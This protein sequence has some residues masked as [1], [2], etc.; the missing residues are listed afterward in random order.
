MSTQ[1]K[2]R[3]CVGTSKRKTDGWQLPLI[4]AVFLSIVVGAF[5][6][7]A[8]AA[9]SSDPLME[10]LIQKGMLTREEADKVKAE[11]EAM[12]TNAPGMEAM[13]AAGSKWK[14]SDAIKNLELFGDARVRYEHRE[15]STPVSDRIDLDRARLALRVGLRGEAF[16]NFYYGLRLDTSSNPRSPW[17]TLGASSPSPFGKSAFGINVGQAY[18]GWR[19]ANWLDVELGK[20]ANPLYTT[21]M[22]WDP[23]LNPEGVAERLKGT[24]GSAD[25]F[26]NFGQFLYQDNNPSY[27]SG[28]LL[29]A[30]AGTRLQ[31]YTQPTFMLAWQG[32]VNYHFT[33]DVALQVA[34]TLYQY[35]G[36][37]T[38]YN[39]LGIGD[40]FVGE[41]SYGGPGSPAPI[42]GLTSQNGVGYNQVGVNHLLVLDVPVEFN[43]KVG[44]LH[45]R[46][47]G[48]YSYNLEGS[49]RAEAA[50]QALQSQSSALPGNAPPLLASG[51]QRNDVHAYQVG[52]GIGSAGPVYGPSQGLVYE[53][54]SKKNTWEIRTYWQ[55]VEQY[56]LDPNLLDSDFF[57]GRG[58]MQGIFAALAYG[59]SGSTIATIRYG[60]AERINNK[61]GTGG[62]N[63]DIPQLNPIQRYNILQ[64]D[65]TLRF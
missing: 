28:S 8:V 17:V 56:A 15:A 10:L 38:N 12:R 44:P 34:P 60:Y 46:V 54:T 57:E 65:L 42:D 4:N 62:S 45:A 11:S 61:L 51:P 41:G 33:T 18:L 3:R 29:P 50:V 1:A 43:F 23:D 52:F 2:R 30:V 64:V 5:C 31:N 40:A 19:P 58:N 26:A 53:N 49:Q 14:I 32:V 39:G 47:F 21:P 24:V 25:F 35:V 6:I 16:D 37:M 9:D 20:M 22:V 36:L 7:R 48:D 27:I 63:L 59:L 55:H 13:P